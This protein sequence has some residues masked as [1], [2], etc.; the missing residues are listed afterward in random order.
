MEGL[1]AFTISISFRCVWTVLNHTEKTYNK[2]KGF[3]YEY[4]I[5]FSTITTDKA[6]GENLLQWLVTPLE[7]RRERNTQQES[8]WFFPSYR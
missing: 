7:S 6:L 1:C 8:T 3:V 4:L 2:K 5:Q